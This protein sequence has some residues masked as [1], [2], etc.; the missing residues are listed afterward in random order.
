MITKPAQMARHASKLLRL[1]EH[2]ELLAA[3]GSGRV[4]VDRDKT[5]TL[6]ARHEPSASTGSGA[7][8]RW[9]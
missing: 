9:W 3:T 6:T 7:Q 8:T 4:V 1:A 2:C 5:P